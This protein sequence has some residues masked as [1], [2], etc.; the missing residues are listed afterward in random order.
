MFSSLVSRTSRLSN[1]VLNLCVGKLCGQQGYS[2]FRL[3]L[4]E[5]QV[6]SNSGCLDSLLVTW[7]ARKRKHMDCGS[8]QSFELVCCV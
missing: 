7:F 4:G 8:S 1:E 2:L 6:F 3:N 5:G